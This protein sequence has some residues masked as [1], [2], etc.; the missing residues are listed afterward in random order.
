M[1]GSPILGDTFFSRVSPFG[2]PFRLRYNAARGLAVRI[3]V[4]LGEPL[5][6]AVGRRRLALDWPD[7]L[8]VTPSQA[9]ARL[10]NEY[11]DFDAAFRCRPYR[12]FVDAKVVTDEGVPMTDGQTLYLLLPAIGG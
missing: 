11:P 8:K 7:A 12:L 2:D 6:R 4:K 3:Y 1:T 10:A 9:L 5:W